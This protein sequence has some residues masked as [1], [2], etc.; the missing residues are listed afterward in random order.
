MGLGQHGSN[1]DAQLRG[2]G[3]EQQQMLN[4]VHQAY[5]QYA[6]QQAAQQ[7][8]PALGIHPQQQTKM[9]MLNPASV[10]DQEMRMGNLKMQDIMSM[11]A[12]N[13]TQGSSS[14][15]SSEHVSRGE[16]PM[17][18]GQQIRPLQATKI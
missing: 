18:Q 6:F 3:S 15:S 14:R 2:Q 1:Q 11:Q 4:P 7:K 17:E 10:K 5:L 9:G 16:K 12:M 8:Q 13:Q